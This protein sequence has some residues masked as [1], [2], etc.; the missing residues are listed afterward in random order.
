MK[1]NSHYRPKGVNE[2]IL[3]LIINNP[4]NPIYSLESQVLDNYPVVSD[5]LSRK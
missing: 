5:K 4:L 1:L 2:V 3:Q